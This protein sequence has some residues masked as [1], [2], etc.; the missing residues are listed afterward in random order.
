M[1]QQVNPLQSQHPS[2]ECLFK[3]S[4]C[5]F[6]SS[7]LVAHLGKQ[8]KQLGPCSLCGRPGWKS[9]LAQAWMLQ[10]LGV[11]T[12]GWKSSVSLFLSLYLSNKYILFIYFIYLVI[13]I[14]VQYVK[15]P[16]VM[17]A[18]HGFKSWLLCFQTS[19]LLMCWGWKP[20]MRLA[21][22]LSPTGES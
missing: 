18:F 16:S 3:S 4:C 13:G 1:A 2:S 12:S 20:Q 8:V 11:W 15:P 19:S 6:L 17:P 7:L 9:W 10:L 22:S 21:C 5:T 14:V